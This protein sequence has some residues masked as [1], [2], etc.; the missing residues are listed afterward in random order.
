M[1]RITRKSPLLALAAIILAIVVIVPLSPLGNGRAV[2]ASGKTITMSGQVVNA[3]ASTFHSFGDSGPP[4]GTVDVNVG[5]FKSGSAGTAQATLYYDVFTFQWDPVN[6]YWQYVSLEN[7]FGTIPSSAVRV[8]GGAKP[9]GVTLTVDTSTL[10]APAFQQTGGA[11]GL[12]S[13]TW[14]SVPGF[15]FMRRGSEKNTFGFD[16]Q[17]MSWST[18]G[19]PYGTSAAAQGAVNGQALP[20]P[21]ADSHNASI[22]ASQGVSA[23]RGCTF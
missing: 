9:S 6:G 17:N 12:I 20:A 16:G 22:N 2:A 11:G 5:L 3:F 13:I 4:P 18:S 23:C 14:K 15:T 10:S 1:K 21:P 19:G 7:G 8:S